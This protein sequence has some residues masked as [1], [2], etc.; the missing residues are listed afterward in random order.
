VQG[1]IEDGITQICR[2]LSGLQNTGAEVRRPY[3]PGLLAETCGQAGQA[4]ETLHLLDE[5]MALADNTGEHWP[6]VEPHRLKGELL[7]GLSAEKHA[8]AEAAYVQA[9]A[10][11]R[12]QE[13]K[14]PELRAT[15]SLIR[16]WQHQ[17]RRAEAYELL[18]PIYG[19]FTE[20]FET[21]DPQE[22]KALLEELS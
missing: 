3:Y 21:T 14:A 1:Q 6:E 9:L 15:K 7:F 4:E 16:L 18:A 10:L 19:W 5:A 11:A 13:A 20:G 12:R 22:A 17:G 2:G 8:E